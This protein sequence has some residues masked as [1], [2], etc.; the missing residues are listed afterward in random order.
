MNDCDFDELPEA[1][2]CESE[3]VDETYTLKFKEKAEDVIDVI[4][5]S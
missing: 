2:T 5:E 4:T 1:F 3:G